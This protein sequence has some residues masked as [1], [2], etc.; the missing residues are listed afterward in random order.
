MIV[1]RVSLKVSVTLP[2]ILEPRPSG[3]KIK[4]ETSIEPVVKLGKHG[5]KRRDILPCVDR[6]LRSFLLVRRVTTCVESHLSGLCNL[7][8]PKFRVRTGNVNLE[9]KQ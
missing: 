1:T 8:E 2:Y 9:P 7:W 4:T 5:V 6:I 3:P